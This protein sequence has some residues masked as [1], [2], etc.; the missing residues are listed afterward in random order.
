M[1]FRT[2][3]LLLLVATSAV[4]QDLP[5]IRGSGTSLETFEVQLR[6]EAVD[7]TTAEGL[8]KSFA[9]FEEEQHDVRRSFADLVREAHLD[10]LRRFYTKDLV[11][12]QAKDYEAVAQKGYRSEVKGITGEGDRATAQLQRT[13]IVAGK[14]RDEA[15]EIDLVREGA[16]WRISA[17][18]DR[19]RDGQFRERPLGAPPELKRAPVP[20]PGAPDLSTPKAAISSLRDEILRF[21]GLR[22]NAALSLNDRFFDITAAFFGDEVARKARE[23]RPRAKE[24]QPVSVDVGDGV[25]R[26]ADLMRVDVTVY[27]EA[28]G[29]RSPI[30]QAAFD[31]R[32]EDG[33]WKVVGEFLRP[34]PDAPPNPVPRNFGLFFLVRR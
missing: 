33:K 34:D 20:A 25:P 9:R 11:D 13:Y 26:L 27:E 28:G 1:G 14:Q 23:D 4:A 24:S 10:V 7:H 32:P 8:A 22:D 3:A 18:R 30:G 12:R 6:L 2:T 31:L 17:I 16:R 19:G 29:K 15:T 21:G 5:L